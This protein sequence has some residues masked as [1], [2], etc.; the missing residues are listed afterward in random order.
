MVEVREKCGNFEMDI[1]WQLCRGV[2]LSKVTPNMSDCLHKE[3][4]NTG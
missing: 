1:E 4:L 2:S 3:Y